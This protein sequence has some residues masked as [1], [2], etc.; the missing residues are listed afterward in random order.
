MEN[1]VD[2]AQPVDI[3]N[4]ALPL[5][6]QGERCA[7][8][9]LS[10]QAEA[11][12]KQAWMFT[13][14]CEPALASTAAWSIAWLL[15]QMGSY[16]EAAEWFDRVDTPPANG[17]NIWPLARRGLVQVCRIAANQPLASAAPA[18]LSP[19]APGAA[20]HPTPLPPLQVVNLGSFHVIRDGVRLPVC[21]TRKSLAILRYLL[22]RRH[23]AAHKEELMELLWPDAGPPE[24]AHSLH[25]AVSALRRYLDPREGSYV[26]FRA[27]SYTINPD[28]P[29]MSDCHIFQQLCD[30]AEQPW[31]A[32]DLARA[33]Q[34]YI[35]AVDHYQGDYYVDA[36]DQAWAIT[37]R[38]RLLA[39]YLLALDRLGRIFIKQGYFE[40]AID[41]YQ[42]LLE[43]DSLREDAHCQLMRCYQQLGQRGLALRQYKRCMA[44]LANDLGLEPT[45]ETR[46]LYQAVLGSAD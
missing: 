7:L 14:T 21:N 16:S 31:R 19:N 45:E 24:A 25:V 12:L 9:G 3:R 40:P 46:A 10:Q 18:Q 37:E 22:T 28:A 5:L 34:F 23:Y 32:A 17:R 44:I 4:I 26:L 6:R 30:E 39:R 35:R 11:L 33:Q 20:A 38:E 42:R 36:Q 43:R 29:I 15:V 41:S 13:A 1:Q 2:G 27:D 8:A